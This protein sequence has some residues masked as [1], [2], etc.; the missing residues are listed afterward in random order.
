M[1]T[2]NSHSATLTK[3]LAYLDAGLSVVPVACDGT[4]RPDTTRLP[5]VPGDDGLYHPSWDPLKAEPAAREEVAR[6]F[7][8]GRPPG[9]GVIGGAV[10][11]ALETIDFDARAEEVFPAW[12]ELVEA[13][14][15]GLIERLSVAHTPK[16]GYHARYRCP[17]IDIPGNQKLAVDPAAP[18]DE[19]CLIETRG[20]GG[21][22]I[23]PGSP[24]EVHKSARPY[25]H[26]SGPELEHVLTIGIEEREVLIRAARSFDRS[27]AA[28]PTRASTSTEAK[29]SPGDDFDRRGPGWAALL[30]PHGWEDV[31]RKNGVIYWRRP[32]KTGKS[33]SATTGRCVSKSGRE[34]FAVYSSNADPFPGPEGGRSCSTHGKFAV[35]ALLNHGGDFGAAARALY[36]QGYGE[37]RQ[38]EKAEQVA[39]GGEPNPNG[40][41]KPAAPPA[42]FA[43]T[44]VDLTT[45]AAKAIRPEMLV[46]RVLVRHQPMI[47]GAPHKTLKT[48][49]MCD[50]AVS[51]ATGTPFLGE[52]PVPRPVKVALFSGE[53]GDWTLFKTF[54][55][56]CQGRALDFAATVGRLVVQADGLPQLS[57]VEHMRHLRDALAREA[58]EVFILDPLYLTLLAGMGRDAAQASN[59][60]E[61]GP[62]FQNITRACLD[63]G[64]T[65]CLVHHT[66][67]AAAGSREPL[68]LEDLAYAG[69]AE[70][71]RQWVLLSRR[72]TYD[73][74]SPGSHRLWM[75]AGGSAGHGGLWALDIEEGEV[76]DDLEGRGWEVSVSTATEAR[77]SVKDERDAAIRGEKAQ[78]D[79]RDDSALAT[80]VDRLTANGE[81]LT[82]EGKPAAGY[83][84][85]RDL[86]GLSGRRMLPAVDRLVRD[87]ALRKVRVTVQ[88]GIAKGNAE[89]LQ[90]VD[91]DC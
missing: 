73:G 10:S 58:I 81:Y 17:D 26:F 88:A 78:Q 50:M 90:R 16:P 19:R 86:A 55:R 2:S 43:W 32:G 27:A 54:E 3:A 47:V 42:G 8:G 87:G 4:K 41:D 62:L 23:A 24:V 25:E 6:W 48:S 71:A 1:T 13:E 45:L 31:W 53:S 7:A 66:K 28:E 38:G 80:A 33:W 20:E 82:P 46:R 65:P 49:V 12:R 61:M 37:R 63:A 83:T 5:R 89:G 67:R 79:A 60:Y 85:A 74:A 75:N 52:F 40:D 72:E 36:E 22:A 70:F 57:N 59:L 51:L 77:Q 35:Y 91:D 9:I 76:N 84:A 68:G 14:A 30:R 29:L 64:A 69:V 44:A 18:P 39:G 15:P 11:G 21:Y 34:L 56:V